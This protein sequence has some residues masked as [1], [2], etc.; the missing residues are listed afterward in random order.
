MTRLPFQ[1]QNGVLMF[2]E[3]IES[4][5]DEVRLQ[6]APIQFHILCAGD[7]GPF[8]QFWDDLCTIQAKEC[9]PKIVEG[10]RILLGRG[11]IL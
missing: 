10:V 6:F 3:P 5:L 8:Y 9:L 7:L 4:S 1:I 11:L 2:D